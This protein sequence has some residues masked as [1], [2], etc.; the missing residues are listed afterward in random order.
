LRFIIF[1]Q[2]RKIE[3][4]KLEHEN[5]LL[6]TSN[7]GPHDDNVLNTLLN[8]AKG[9]KEEAEL[10]FISFFFSFEEE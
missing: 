3:L 9:A 10:V 1:Y 4:R 7:G 6:R 8:E 5:K 2:C